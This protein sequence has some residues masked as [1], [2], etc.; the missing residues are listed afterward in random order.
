[1]NEPPTSNSNSDAHPK[2]HQVQYAVGTLGRQQFDVWFLRHWDKGHVIVDSEERKVRVWQSANPDL[3]YVRICVC[4][5]DSEVIVVM[6]F[7]PTDYTG[8]P[9]EDHD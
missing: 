6:N 8:R 9:A 2:P 3:E 1:M 4:L 7:P 5:N